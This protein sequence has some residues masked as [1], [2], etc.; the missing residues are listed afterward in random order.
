LRKGVVVATI[1]EH[2]DLGRRIA[3]LQM[4]KDPKD[5]MAFALA[6]KIEE[7]TGHYFAAVTLPTNPSHSMKPIRPQQ[8]LSVKRSTP[9]R[10]P[11]RS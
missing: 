6:A 11:R 2:Y 1:A 7:R 4:Q 5:A 3:S 8:R 10:W 9:S